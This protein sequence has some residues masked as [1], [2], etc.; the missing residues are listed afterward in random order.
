MAQ[1]EKDLDEKVKAAQQS[2]A[3]PL[4]KMQD[5][6]QAALQKTQQTNAQSLTDKNQKNQ[7]QV[8]ASIDKLQQLITT[9]N[10]ALNIIPQVKSVK[11][12]RVQ[13]VVSRLQQLTQGV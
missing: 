8:K 1:N 9:V 7:R 13:E 12:P 3:A 10:G 5:D 2:Y 4:K 11:D 6:L